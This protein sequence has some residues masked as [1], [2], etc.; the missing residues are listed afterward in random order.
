MRITPGTQ[1]YLLSVEFVY[2]TEAIPGD[3][4]DLDDLSDLE[5]PEAYS[6]L[7]NAFPTLDIDSVE[8]DIQALPN[9]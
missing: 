2:E 6:A 4:D 5:L 9:T 8:L 3:P 7:R 1:K